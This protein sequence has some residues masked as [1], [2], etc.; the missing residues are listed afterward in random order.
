MIGMPGREVY[1][2]RERRD[3]GK[4]DWE[5]GEPDFSGSRHSS[6]SVEIS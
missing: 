5:N 3:D 4:L 6:I 1:L 2:R